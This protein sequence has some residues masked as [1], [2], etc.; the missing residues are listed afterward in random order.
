MIIDHN[1]PMYLSTWKSLGENQFNGAYYYSKEI[2]KYIIPKVKTDRNWVTIN[3]RGVCPGHSIVFIHNNLCPERYAWL[4]G[5]K[6]LILVCGV[7]KTA[8]SLAKYHHP[9]IVL[10]LS[11]NIADVKQYERPKTKECAFAGRYSKQKGY[12]FPDNCDKLM[13]L[14]RAKLLP[15]MAEYE[16]IYA[17][18]RTAIEAKILGCE[19]LPY[20]TRYPDPSIW[21]VLDC[22]DAAKILQEK[23]DKVEEE[24][25]ND[26]N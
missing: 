8:N 20:D 14:P 9:T 16:Q 6:D 24:N 26:N 19:I 7:Q 1:H 5:V 21:K 17:V 4:E 12:S 11:V 18:G 10:P 3:I 2:V 23:L 25:Y 15:A 13:G 22:A